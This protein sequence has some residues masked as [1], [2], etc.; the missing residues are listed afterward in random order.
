[1]TT[2]NIARLLHHPGTSFRPICP[3]DTANAS[4]TKTHWSAVELHHIMGCWKFRNYKHLL[5]VSRDGEWVDRG[6][7][8]SSLGSYATIPKAK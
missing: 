6:E 3:C 1:M 8:P 2:D 7:F 5:Q 4:D